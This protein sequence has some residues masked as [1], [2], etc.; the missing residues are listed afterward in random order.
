M[1]FS[2]EQVY[3]LFLEYAALF[4]VG[5]RFL[6]LASSRVVMEKGLAEMTS[7]AAKELLRGEVGTPGLHTAFEYLL[8]IGGRPVTVYASTGNARK[9]RA[10]EYSAV[11]LY[12]RSD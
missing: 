7:N 3:I 11:S 2:P 9:P 12:R 5:I 10:K 6:W 8:E 4:S 1:S